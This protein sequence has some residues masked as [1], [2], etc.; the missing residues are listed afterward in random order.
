[1]SANF[2]N[3][4]GACAGID[5]HTFVTIGPFGAPIPLPLQGHAIAVS[6][7]WA[8]RSW[9]IAHSV[10]TDASPVL[11]NNWAAMLVP[12]V[13]LATAPPHPAEAAVLVA[14][15]AASS[16]APQ[17]S[18]HKVTAEGQA[19]CTAISGLFGLN[20][21]CSDMPALSY[22]INPNSVMTQPT[23]GDYIG[24]IISTALSCAVS[25]AQSYAMGKMAPTD[26]K[27][28]VGAG[29]I[30]RNLNHGNV[31]SVASAV[32]TTLLDIITGD[33]VANTIGLISG[34]AQRAA[35]GEPLLG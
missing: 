21:D 4:E 20:L 32:A 19:L 31:F 2:L 22:D 23:L 1:M 26:A 16:A 30:V 29:E 5:L 33:P 9:R 6:H 35:D 24:A 28:G 14:I 12:H 18:A 15:I 10:T 27:P 8:S 34:V 11:Q 25:Y 7:S 17:L 13:P 3:K